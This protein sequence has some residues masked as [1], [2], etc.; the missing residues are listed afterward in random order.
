VRKNNTVRGEADFGYCA[1]KDKYY[2]GFKG[3]LV[4][5]H[6]GLIREYTMTAANIDERDVL[7]ELIEGYA[8]D[9]IADK[10]LIRPELTKLLKRQRLHL[11][12]TLRANMKDPRPKSFI[13]NIINIRRKIETMIGQLPE[14]FQIQ[15]IHVKDLFHLS[16]K[17]GRKILA[18]TMAF[19][20][21]GSLKFYALLA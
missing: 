12:T 16:V 13:K 21:A 3:H 8:G 11:H 6:E 2:F 4:A 18:H 15:S 1:T 9:L 7:T 20:W 19:F 10:G 17:V 14:R 5:D